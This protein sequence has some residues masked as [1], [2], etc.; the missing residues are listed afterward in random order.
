[1]KRV[2]NA[3]LVTST[4]RLIIRKASAMFP[5]KKALL[6]TSRNASAGNDNKE[7]IEFLWR[8]VCVCIDRSS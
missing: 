8:G 1:M 2:Q 6:V 5:L 3:L 4:A 7:T